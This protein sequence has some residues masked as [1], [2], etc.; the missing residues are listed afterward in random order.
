DG[1]QRTGSID[2]SP[3]DCP[4][5]REGVYRG[6]HKNVIARERHRGA[7]RGI[8]A[9][10]FAVP[11]HPAIVAGAEPDRGCGHHDAWTVRVRT[12]LMDVAVDGDGRL[13]GYAAVRRPRDTADVDVGEEHRPVRGGSYRADPERRSDALTV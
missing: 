5:S 4:P 13:P 11:C 3:V 6:G 9:L 7:I 2:P 1:D 12:N 10:C 8:Q